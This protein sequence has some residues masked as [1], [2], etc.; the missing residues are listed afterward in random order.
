MP[1]ADQQRPVRH[2]PDQTSLHDRVRLNRPGHGENFA[3]A[4]YWYR[5]LAPRGVPLPRLLDHDAAPADDSFPFM[6][7]S[8]LP[9]ED[10]DT[11]YPDLT[12][13]QKRALAGEMVAIQTSA[14]RLPLGPRFGY[15]RSYADPTLHPSWM[16]FLQAELTWSR[17]KIHAVGLVDPVCADRVAM[18]L[19][20]YGP[21][22]ATVQ[23][24]CF[25]DDI[26]LKNV[27]VQDGRLSGIVDV[28]WVCFGD[29]LLPLALSQ[30]R[31][32]IKGWD[33][34]YVSSSAA[35]MELGEEERQALTLYSVRHRD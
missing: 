12:G 28:D 4:V 17:A 15:A 20:R 25:L 23:P 33:T 3:G 8:R 11:A 7:T 30:L 21:Y 35:A 32:L 10:L 34:E 29:A 16:A 6:I 18:K 19:D 2:V 26:A 27:L 5:R 22:L 31:L 13:L 24:H 9:G 14:G 1:A